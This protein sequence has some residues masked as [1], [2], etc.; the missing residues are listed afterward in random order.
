MAGRYNPAG[1]IPCITTVLYVFFA[2][3]LLKNVSSAKFVDEISPASSEVQLR[4]KTLEQC[5]GNGTSIYVIPESERTCPCSLFVS[6]ERDSPVD[7]DYLVVR[8]SDYDAW[9][10]TGSEGNLFADVK[11]K[12]I[13]PDLSRGR[14]RIDIPNEGQHILVV[15]TK[16][17]TAQCVQFDYMFVAKDRKFCPTRMNARS[18]TGE[19]TAISHSIIAGTTHVH[20]KIQDFM[21]GVYTEGRGAC[22]G[23]V[24]GKHWILTAAHCGPEANY[25][26]IFVG[27][28]YFSSGI[29][30]VVT[31]AF[32]HP[33]YSSGA[34]LDGQITSA[35]INDVALL[36]TKM[37]IDV[38][39]IGV[40][41]NA[42]IPQA[43]DIVRAV[44]YGLTFSSSERGSLNSV[45]VSEIPM[46]KCQQDYRD[47][48]GGYDLRGLSKKHHLCAGPDEVCDG[49]VCRGKYKSKYF[50]KLTNPNLK[51][52]LLIC[53]QETVEGPLW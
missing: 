51:I 32:I 46:T 17:S 6:D 15:R 25:T 33:K 29:E 39:P 18:T 48:T 49:G 13:P 50:R 21:V 35:V 20:K 4:M 19:D 31:E 40:N 28:E 43:R 24:I 10:S 37:P 27:G 3:I 23:S 44:G 5:V 12:I 26:R 34:G 41:N 53:L 9:V 22:T 11:V 1:K 52:I 8:K 47:V 30:H 16:A 45:D 2:L 14:R 36:R 7:G 38:T 42:N